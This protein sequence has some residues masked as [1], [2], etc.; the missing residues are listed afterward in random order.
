LAIRAVATPSTSAQECVSCQLLTACAAER[1]ADRSDARD[2]A[3]D[4]ITIPT[5]GSSGYPNDIECHWVATCGAP[6]VELHFTA[7][8]VESNQ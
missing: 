1:L 8:D 4:V 7:F 3:Q 5:V 6:P 2:G